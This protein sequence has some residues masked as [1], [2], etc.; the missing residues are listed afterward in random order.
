MTSTDHIIAKFGSIS[1]LARALGHKHSSTVQGWKEKGII[2]PRRY[3]EILR[4]ARATGIEL[5]PEDFIAHLKNGV[6]A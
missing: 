1:A 5:E 6:A 3:E 2:P 4:A